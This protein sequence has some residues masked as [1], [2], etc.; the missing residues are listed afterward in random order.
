MSIPKNNTAPSPTHTIVEL[1]GNTVGQV[2]ER[3]PAILTVAGLGGLGFVW[4]QALTGSNNIAEFVGTKIVEIGGY[5]AA[6][7]SPIGWTVHL[8]IS[9][10]Y[11]LFFATL[12]ALPIWPT[13]SIR[14]GVVQF[15]AALGVGVVATWIANP[16]I[17]VTVSMLGG[18]GWPAELYPVNTSLGVPLYNHL[19]FFVATLVATDWIPTCLKAASR[20]LATA[21][22]AQTD[23]L[24]AHDTVILP[25]LGT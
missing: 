14:R 25:P 24:D 23:T 5:D 17:S 11:A 10:Q 16:A 20:T 22:D 2:R 6:L 18:A 19:G 13:Q 15:A 8:A 7:A 9:V 1:A 4:T 3:M 12:L 21:A